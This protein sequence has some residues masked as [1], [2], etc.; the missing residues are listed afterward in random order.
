MRDINPEDIVKIIRRRFEAENLDRFFTIR[1]YNATARSLE[2]SPS[3]SIL[4]EF[5][6]LKGEFPDRYDSSVYRLLILLGLHAETEFSHWLQ[7]DIKRIQQRDNIDRIVLWSTQDLSDE[8]IQS[9]KNINFFL[10]KIPTQAE[11]RGRVISHFIPIDG[12]SVE[13]SLIANVTAEH[14]TRRLKKLFHLVLSEI[15]A[16]IYDEKYGKDRVATTAIM[17]FEEKQLKG[18]IK[19][20]VTEGK[21]NIAVD[22]GC[23]TG[24]HS[25]ILSQHFNRVYAYDF[26]PKMIDEAE[27]SKR[28]KEIRN[29]VFA[30][31]DFE[32]E[33]LLDESQFY[34]EC[35]LVVASFGMGSFIED[36]SQMLRRFSDWLKPGGYVF[37]TFYNESSITLKI[38]PNWRDVSL[39]AQIDTEGNSLEV[40]LTPD[41]R[42]HIFC[43][44]F[45]DGV[46]GVINKVFNICDIWTYPTVMALLP[47]SLLEDESA[48][49]LFSYVDE[50]LSNCKEHQLGHYVIVAAEKPEVAIEGFA[51]IVKLLR[52]LGCEYEILEHSPV[53]SIEDVKREIGYHPRC[54]VKTIIFK[55]KKAETFISVS[56]QSE[57]RVDKAKLGRSLQMSVSRLKFAPEKQVLKLGFPIGGIAPFG[58]NEGIEVIKFIDRALDDV[59]GEYLY[60]GIGDNRK[61]LKLRREDFFNIV[62]DYQ[63]IEL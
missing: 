11:I 54:M 58:F 26:S 46:K 31:N 25:F 51:N 6:T 33:T 40:T 13:Y 48:H 22:I 16:P 57:K 53:L 4:L 52:D 23:G 49:T 41:I 35:D 15:A 17:E 3:N 18:L 61:T 7:N 59:E 12:K 39:A 34:G 20:L 38:I 63:R 62:R 9:L 24:R 36:T 30:V 47:N 28:R 19:K 14:I 44:P 32:Y 27:R 5:P 42:F 60:M 45:S 29:I 50:M 37:V 1:S 10:V 2:L 56:L 43:R 8:I 55:D 21:S